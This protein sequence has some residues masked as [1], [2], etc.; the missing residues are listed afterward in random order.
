MKTVFTIIF[1]ALIM[2]SS[3]FAKSKTHVLIYTKNETGEGMYIH[4]N[5]EASVKALQ[6]ICQA[7][8][9]TSDVSDDPALFTPDNLKQY[10]VLI[11][12]NS[13]N[14]AFDNQAQRDAF[15]QYIQNGGRF[16]GIHSA[17]ASERDWPWF[18]AMVGGTFVR[19]P[20]LQEF[21]IKVIDGDHPSTQHLGDTWA[22]ED[23]CYLLHHLNPDIKVVLA[24]DLTTIKDDK[25]DEFPGTMFGDY[26][27]IAWYHTFDGGRQFYTALG[28][29]IEYYQDENFI[30]HLEGGLLWLLEK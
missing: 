4:D 16:M 6:K 17:C 25:L 29:K 9:I 26:F 22:W 5:I 24:A 3:V 14:K 10:D 28:H 20:K 1:T 8:D 30:K 13:N 18:W 19:H 12:S 23:E 27:P 2:L 7:H 21:D 15:Q 11:F